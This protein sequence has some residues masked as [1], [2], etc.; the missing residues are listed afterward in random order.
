[1]TSQ[2]ITYLEFFHSISEED[3]EEIAKSFQPRTLVE[4]DYLLHPNHICRELFFIKEGILRIIV[5]NEK[6]NPITYFFLKENQFCTILKSFNN[7]TITAEGI[8]AACDVEVLAINRVELLGLYER[9]PYLK[10]L[11]DEITQRALLD[12][13]ELKNSYLGHDSTARYKLFIMQQ[14]DIAMRVS[15]SDV[16]SYL[17]ITQQSLSRIRRN[18]R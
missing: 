2:L 3:K 14:A 15:L 18:I 16:A 11:I 8:Q 12:K 4:G 5:Q 7:Q 6:G 10:N 13:I 1:M 9:L 17:G